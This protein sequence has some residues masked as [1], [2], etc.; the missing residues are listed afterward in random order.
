MVASHDPRLVEIAGA[1]AAQHDRDADSFEY[2]MLYGIRPEEQKRIADRGDQM[3]VYIPYGEEWYGYLMRRMAERPA[4]IVFFLRG[5][6]D[7]G[8]SRWRTD[9]DL[10]RRGDGRDPAVRA[11]PRRAATPATSSSPSGAPTAPTQLDRAATACACWTTSRRPRSPTPWCWCV[12]PQDMAALLE[13]D[14]RPRCA[15]A[16]LVVSASPPASPPS[17]SR[18]G[19]PRA[20][21]SS[22]SCPT[23][24]PW[25]TRAWPRSSPGQHCDDDAPRRG[26][27]AAALV[28]QGRPARREAPGRRHRDLRLRPGLHLLRRRG[29]DR[30]RRRARACPA[31]RP[32]SSSSRPCTARRRCSRRPASTRRCCASRSPHPAARPSP[33]CA[34]STTTRCARRSSPR[35]RPPRPARNELASGQV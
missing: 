11:D 8:L 26:R 4:N 15:R 31:R 1:L 6:R 24:R 30:G 21:P 29:D 32:P 10:R 5:A 7:Q 20:P 25:S 35:W 17:T 34:S 23:P 12:K 13:R 14:P 18:A 16:T 27:G 28:R 19:C 2:Q 33:R 22:G 3:R 9:R